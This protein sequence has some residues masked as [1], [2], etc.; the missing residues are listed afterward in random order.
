[1]K[2]HNSISIYNVFLVVAIGGDGLLLTVGVLF[3]GQESLH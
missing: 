2:T 3:M 1:M